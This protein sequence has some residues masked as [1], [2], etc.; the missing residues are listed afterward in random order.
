MDNACSFD[1][2]APKLPNETHNFVAIDL[3]GHGYSTHFPLGMTYRLS[4]TFTVLR[5]VKDCMDWEKFSI[6]GHSLGAGIGIWYSSIFNEEVDRLIS[7]DLVNVAPLT[8]ESHVK[9]T[10]NSILSGVSTFNKLSGAKIPT[11]EYIDAVSRA[12]MA[13][14]M[15]HGINSI[16]QESVETLMKRGLTKVGDK[17]TWSADLR[18]R[19]PPAFYT[20]EEQVLHYAANIK[21][22]MMLLKAA[23][24]HYY[25]PAEIAKRI[26]KTYINHNPN[27]EMHKIQ[28]GHHVHLNQPERV[29]DL[30]CEFLLKSDFQKLEEEDDEKAGKTGK[31]DFPLDLF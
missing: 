11:Y 31:T 10:K 22:P 24:S 27:F 1:G 25:M 19:V 3:P 15:A 6:I 29:S 4:D 26:I 9:R 12:F 17:Y 30:I 14:Q 23:E 13:N 7:L 28:G 18:L 2:L 16:T 5:Y 20:V 8:L 21:C